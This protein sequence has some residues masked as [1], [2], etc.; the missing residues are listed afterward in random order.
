[1]VFDKALYI[2]TA[3]AY[4]E[5]LYALFYLSPPPF[6]FG[7]WFDAALLFNWPFHLSC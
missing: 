1:M 3:Y 7:C 6:Y 2:S 5:S 4:A